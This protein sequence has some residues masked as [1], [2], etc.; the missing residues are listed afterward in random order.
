MMV[1]DIHTHS[2]PDAI[3]KSAIKTLED[4]IINASKT[5][6]R[7]VGSGNNAGLL[8]S[9]QDGGIDISVIL[10]I[11]TSPKQTKTINDY[12]QQVSKSENLISF[13]SI[14]PS[15]A[16]DCDRIL[17][18]LCER[19]FLGIKLH[20]E[21]QGSDID[22]KEMLKIINKC[23]ELGLLTVVHAGIDAGFSPSVH[24]LPKQLKNALDYTSGNNLI[25]AHMGGWQCWDDVQ[26]YIIGRNIMIDTSLSLNFMSEKDATDM[27]K[28][29]GTDK[30]LFGTDWPWFSQ[31]ESVE[32]VSRLNL[33]DD[34]KN[35]ILSENAKKILKI[36]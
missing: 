22:S 13:G 30:V 16:D 17:E 4:N 15:Q 27:I 34:E 5:D 9:M 3:Y 28:L 14:H 21:Y 23:D 11:A 32:L 24:C 1:I 31:K 10:P 25:A 36:K 6:C 20:P 19:G 26:K 12:A 7:A 8:Q 29:H 2:F 33:T 18:D 35:K